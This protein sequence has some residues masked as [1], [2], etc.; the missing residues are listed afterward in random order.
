MPR[1]L[2]RPVLAALAAI[3]LI[4]TAVAA[5][6]WHTLQA[7]HCL[8]VSQLSEHDTRKWA[9]QF[10]QFTAAV[11]G[12][13][14]IDDRFLPPLTV[15]LF[16]DRGKFA[17][18]CP[19]TAAGKKRDVAGYFANRDTWSVIGLAESFNN[20]ATRHVVLHESTHWLV[21]ATATELPLWL[22][23][24]FAEVFSTFEVKKDYGLLG[25]PLDYHVAT[26]ARSDWVPLLQ[27][28][29]TSRSSP[30]Y[31]DSNRNAVFYAESWLFV[32][33]LLFKDRAAG[34][35]ALNRFFDAR[36]H[37]ADQLAAFQSSFTKDTADVDSEQIGRAHV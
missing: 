37:G 11:R 27:L 22:N 36:L 15:V 5:P 31:T 29:F 16:A 21:S 1:R 7:P 13:I 3:L 34:Y 35:A 9:T 20:Q 14:R 32:H 24:G 26:L 33:Q 8:I 6:K 12:V 19:R 4:A 10:E 28:M 23:E 25:R 17:P 30:F 2:L 18:Y